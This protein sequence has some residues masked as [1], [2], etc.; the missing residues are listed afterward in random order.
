MN[1]KTCLTVAALLLIIAAVSARGVP[2]G[3]YPG[4]K[5]LI[6]AADAIVVLRI[7]R[8]LSGFGSPTFYSTH[9]CYIY[10]TL[11]GDIPK[12]ARIKLRL[13]NTDG[14]F[15]TPYAHGSTH[16]MFLMKRATKDEPTEYRT[17]T[18]KGAQVLLSPLGHEKAPE[19]RTLEDKVRKLIKDAIAYQA[20]EHEKRQKFLKAMVAQEGTAE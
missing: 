15:A 3:N 19:G 5:K 9:E 7:D 2:I 18:F 12:N 16:L 17:M 10:Q 20:R 11:K 14:S 6:H 1:R 4:L 8:H 13:M